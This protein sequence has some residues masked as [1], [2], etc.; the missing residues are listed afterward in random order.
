MS[1]FIFSSIS[2]TD[3]RFGGARPAPAPPDPY[4]VEELLLVVVDEYVD[5]LDPPFPFV[6]SLDD[7][8]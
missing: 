4:L 3:S 2:S 7:D 6:S 8:E 5:D 1:R